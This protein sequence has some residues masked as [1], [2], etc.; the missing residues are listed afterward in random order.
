MSKQRA[1]DIKLVVVTE[2]DDTPE[3]VMSKQDCITCNL[4]HFAR[5]PYPWGMASLFTLE[6]EHTL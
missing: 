3:Y 2:P 5:N 6:L 4:L 1:T